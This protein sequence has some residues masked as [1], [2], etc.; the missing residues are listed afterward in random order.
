MCIRDRPV[1]PA[2]DSRN[3]IQG[4]N[5]RITMLTEGLVRLEYSEDGIFEDRATQTVINRDFPA[6]DYQVKDTPEEL[7]ILTWRFRLTYDKKEFNPRGLRIHVTGNTGSGN[8]VWHYGDPVHDLK[9]TART[10]DTIDG[11]CE[12]GSGLVSRDGFT[13]LDD[14]ASLIL[15]EEGWVSP[16][17][18]GIKDIYFWGYGLDL[19]LIH[20]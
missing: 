6:V 18:K 4:E 15:T 5:Y 16:R 11:A 17:K 1:R 14:S 9:G 13:V 20:I 3:I 2:A 7:E 19:S 12:L 8:D 10:L